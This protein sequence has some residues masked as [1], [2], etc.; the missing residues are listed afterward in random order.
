MPVLGL[1]VAMGGC[2]S[3]GGTGAAD[4]Q[5]VYVSTSW[6]P[7][8]V[9]LK[10]T[11]TGQDFWSVDVPVGKQ[12]VVKFVPNGGTK[13]GFTPDLMKWS[14]M[15]ADSEFGRTDN[16]LA[17]PPASVRRLDFTLR[18]TPELP[19]GMSPN[20]KPPAPAEPKPVKGTS[21]GM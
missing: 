1:A 15:K 17:V 10:D 2:Y 14:I 3:E 18:P 21:P 8:T 9:T 12:L 4:D 5:Y 6:Q 20:K 7:K 13:D 11:R 16:A 19:D